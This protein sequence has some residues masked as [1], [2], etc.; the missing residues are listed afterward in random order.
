MFK[1]EER[2]TILYNGHW[3]A[4]Y[5]ISWRTGVAEMF[6][7]IVTWVPWSTSLLWVLLSEKPSLLHWPVWSQVRGIIREDAFFFFFFR[8]SNQIPLGKILGDL[9]IQCLTSWVITGL[10]LPDLGF[11]RQYNSLIILVHLKNFFIY[12][13]QTGDQSQNSFSLLS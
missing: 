10:C 1:G 11:L 2:E 5:I 7:L 8:L 6:A 4:A 12:I 3:P 9:S 13:P